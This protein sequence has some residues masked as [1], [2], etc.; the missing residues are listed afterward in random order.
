MFMF[1][2]VVVH[3]SNFHVFVSYLS[4]FLKNVIKQNKFIQKKKNEHKKKKEQKKNFFHALHY[5]FIL[6]DVILYQLH[7]I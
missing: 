1:L 5:F 3:K 7:I 6:I 2:K 4:T